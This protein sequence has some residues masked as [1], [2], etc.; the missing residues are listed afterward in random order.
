[1]SSL[2]SVLPGIGDTGSGNAAY[3]Y[4]LVMMDVMMSCWKSRPVRCIRWDRLFYLSS[5]LLGD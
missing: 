3:I 4:G 2:S 5:L 1:M